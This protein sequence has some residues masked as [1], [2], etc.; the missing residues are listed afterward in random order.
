M[1]V[2]LARWYDRTPGGMVELCSQC[3]MIGRNVGDNGVM[4]RRRSNRDS[5]VRDDTFEGW[6]DRLINDVKT[7]VGFIIPLDAATA[8]RVDPP[9]DP[10]ALTNALVA[11]SGNDPLYLDEAVRRAVRALVDRKMA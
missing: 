6:L 3:G 5:E 9:R 10:E 1:T 8:L 4:S 7:E 2:A 11:A